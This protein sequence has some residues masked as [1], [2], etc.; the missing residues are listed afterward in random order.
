MKSKIWLLVSICVLA[1]A[2]L[3][4]PGD[5]SG[6]LPLMSRKIIENASGLRFS[7]L[8]AVSLSIL[9]IEFNPLSLDM[10]GYLEVRLNDF[11]NIVNRERAMVPRRVSYASFLG[12]TN[13]FFFRFG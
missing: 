7:C 4:L 9:I 5:E 13:G 10:Y 3:F 11:I 6:A 8:V 12:F 2:D 1:F